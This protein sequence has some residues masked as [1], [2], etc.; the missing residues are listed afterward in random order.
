MMSKVQPNKEFEI[1]F[2]K[3]IDK[4]G[5]KT[6]IKWNFILTFKKPVDEMT[7]GVE[8]ILK[9]FMSELGG[10]DTIKLAGRYAVELIIARTFDPDEVIAAI[11]ASLP[12]LQ[13]DIITS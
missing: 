7:G 2:A 4:D 9:F 11:E 5:N 13:S 3:K 6:D 8:G 1:E 10:I 12:T